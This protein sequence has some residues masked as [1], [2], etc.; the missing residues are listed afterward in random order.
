MDNIKSLVAKLTA[1]ED[2]FDALGGRGVDIAE[3]IDALRARVEAARNSGIL[4]IT[5]FDTGLTGYYT[6]E[7]A[8]EHFGK[9]ELQELM[10]G[11]PHLL[12]VEVNA[13]PDGEEVTTL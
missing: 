6:K 8:E 7:W 13:A 11:A 5:S 3:E 4:E 12:I 9:A 10:A 2:R 1:L